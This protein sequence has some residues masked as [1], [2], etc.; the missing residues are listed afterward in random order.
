[1]AGMQAL[2][3]VNAARLAVAHG[4]YCYDCGRFLVVGF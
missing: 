1:M 4:G 2:V 3:V